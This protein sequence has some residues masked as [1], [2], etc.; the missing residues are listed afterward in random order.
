MQ[1]QIVARAE[2]DPVHVH[3]RFGS[4]E[5]AAEVLPA[6]AGAALRKAA[7]AVGQESAVSVLVQ[8]A[9]GRQQDSYGEDAVVRL[10][11]FQVRQNAAAL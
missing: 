10:F 6:E 5:F 2:L 11:T 9:P 3:V 1:G 7:A 4:A 8:A